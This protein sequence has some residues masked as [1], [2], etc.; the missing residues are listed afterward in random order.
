[1]KLSYLLLDVFTTTPL[2]GNPLAVVEKGD[3]LLDNQMQ[4]I[5]KELGLSETVFLAPPVRI[6]IRRGRASSPRRW[7]CRS[8]AIR[9]LGRRWCSG[10]STG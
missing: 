10:C 9:P 4:A 2:T 5:A 3:G 8:P 6:G 1:M 7:S